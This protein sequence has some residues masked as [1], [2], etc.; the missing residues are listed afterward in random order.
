MAILSL[1]SPK[2]LTFAALLKSMEIETM[3]YEELLSARDS[4]KNN[5]CQLMLGKISKREVDGKYINVVDIKKELT[6]NILFSD[7]LNK[8]LQAVS[9]VKSPHQLRYIKGGSDVNQPT[10]MALVVER[11]VFNSLA[12][13]LFESPSLVAR[14]NFVDE[15]VSKAFSAAKDL[16]EQGIFHVCFAPRN[17]LVRKGDSQLLLLNHGSFY[18]DLPDQ[19]VL[20]PDDMTNFIAPEVFAHGII[21]EK[22]DVYSL[23]KLL[24]HLYSTSSM[25]YIVK[26]VVKKA[27]K[28]NPF[29]RYATVEDMEKALSRL[30]STRSSLTM[31]A[32][33]SVAALCIVGAYF[34]IV[35]E[36]NEMEYVKPAP[37]EPE[38]DFLEEGINPIT[39][40]GLRAGDSTTVLTEE[41]KKKMAEYEKKSEEIFRRRFE[42]EADRIISKVYN[43]NTM[44]ASES[45]FMAASQK[46]MEELNSAQEEI[47]SQT[48]MPSAKS[49]L[50]ASQIIDK[51]TNAK[52]KEIK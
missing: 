27:T 12:Q 8:E 11:G 32:V 31:L 50:I 42:R 6:D 36:Q 29:D 5:F 33:A 2:S 43:R 40:L 37:S 24:E 44:G 1:I 20:Y 39:E 34:S 10:G 4:E 46:A 16:H 7:C 38:E 9:S 35:P 13:L 41:Q 51:V 26:R 25:P 22:T 28:E 21:D 30:R 45:K 17:I 15:I 23:G 14:H 52:K 47:A 48:A 49:R 19:D 3:N 18:K